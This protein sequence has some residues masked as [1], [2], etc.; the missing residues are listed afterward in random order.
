MRTSILL[1]DELG[2]QLRLAA[3]AKGL[4]LSAFLAEAGRAALKDSSEA[5]MPP[6]EPV[7]YGSL[8][9]HAGID[10]DRSGAL[11]EADDAEAFGS[12]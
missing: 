3:R 11:I 1:D 4:S 8:G 12:R 6:F 10:L 5:E 9:S 7:T 2:E